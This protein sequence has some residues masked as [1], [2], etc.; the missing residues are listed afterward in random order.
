MNIARARLLSCLLPIIGFVPFM[1]PSPILCCFVL[2]TAFFEW[3][4]PP[5]SIPGT[6]GPGRTAFALRDDF[7]TA[8]RATYH[9]RCRGDLSRHLRCRGV[10]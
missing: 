4:G 5:R 10:I 1:S 6:P 7:S 2:F 8:A 3:L 9:A